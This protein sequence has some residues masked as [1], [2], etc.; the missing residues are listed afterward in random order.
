MKYDELID[1]REKI[2]NEKN[3]EYFPCNY[4]QNSKGYTKE[5]IL[6]N[7]ETDNMIKE[8]EIV[9]KKATID[10]VDIPG[11]DN[12]EIFMHFFPLIT[13]KVQDFYC[14]DGIEKES[15]KKL[16]NNN[17][18]LTDY[19]FVNIDTVIFET[20]NG[21]EKLVDI[22][23]KGIVNF[24]KFV[25][26]LRELGYDLHEYPEIRE[27]DINDVVEILYNGEEQLLIQCYVDF[28]NKK[29]K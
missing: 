19:V 16:I 3:F 13:K 18:I 4:E 27:P 25:N 9:T 20:L 21:N 15:I 7:D 29:I 5:E 14:N 24:N 26:V 10:S 6:K 2:L 8:F 1:L 11:C 12:I 28:K 23:K 22:K 17:E